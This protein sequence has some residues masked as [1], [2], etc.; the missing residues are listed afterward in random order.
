MNVRLSDTDI[1]LPE[2]NGVLVKAVNPFTPAE[3]GNLRVRDVITNIGGKDVESSE[4]A[5]L[6]IDRAAVGKV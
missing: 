1:R 6:F 5:R 3:R 4:D 2:I